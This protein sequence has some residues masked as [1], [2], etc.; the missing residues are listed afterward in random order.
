M[1][2]NRQYPLLKLTTF[3]SHNEPYTFEE[4]V[5]LVAKSETAG[6]FGQHSL[7]YVL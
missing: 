7:V 4:K 3:C 6:V 2:A 1:V 5:S